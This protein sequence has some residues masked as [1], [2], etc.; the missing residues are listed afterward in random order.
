M[1]YPHHN[2]KILSKLVFCEFTIVYTD[3]GSFNTAFVVVENEIYDAERSSY[4]I[5]TYIHPP[6]C[7]RIEFGIGDLLVSTAMLLSIVNN[8]HT[9]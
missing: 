2:T 4:N 8:K 9:S 6:L 1:V 3:L 7:V 5:H